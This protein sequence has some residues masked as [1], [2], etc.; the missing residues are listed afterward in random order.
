MG[1]APRWSCEVV[2]GAPRECVS[3]FEQPARLHIV[4]VGSHHRTEHFGRGARMGRIEVHRVRDQRKH[5][6]AAAVDE[7]AVAIFG[8]REMNEAGVHRVGGAGDRNAPKE[9]QRLLEA[10]QADQVVDQTIA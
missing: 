5:A 2:D 6:G 3:E 4:G 8:Q 1:V 7:Q 10:T 9:L